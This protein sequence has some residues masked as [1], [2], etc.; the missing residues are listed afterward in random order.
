MTSHSNRNRIRVMHNT[1]RIWLSYALLV[2]VAIP[3]YWRWIPGATALV[4]G[5]TNESDA[6]R[7]VAYGNTAAGAVVR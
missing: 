3:W 4:Y 6:S 2:L 7:F 5:V 1:L